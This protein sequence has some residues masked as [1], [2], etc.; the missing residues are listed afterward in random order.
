M[1]GREGTHLLTNCFTISKP[2]P[3]EVPAKKNPPQIIHFVAKWNVQEKHEMIS[4]SNSL[5]QLPLSEHY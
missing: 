4:N 2:S 1:E 3:R 5:Q